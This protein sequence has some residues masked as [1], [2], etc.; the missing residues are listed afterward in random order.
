MVLGEEKG[1][2]TGVQLGFRAPVAA[3]VGVEGLLLALRPRGMAGG[4]NQDTWR[5]Q[6]HVF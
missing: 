5:Q 3:G 1:Q 6:D 4:G 2:E